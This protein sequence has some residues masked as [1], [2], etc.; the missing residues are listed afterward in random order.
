M[1]HLL[2]ICL[3]ALLCS[4]LSNAQTREAD[5]LALVDLYCQTNGLFWTNSWGLDTLGTPP[6]MDGWY[7]VRM[8][9]TL[10]NGEY[11]VTCLD[12]DGNLG[13]HQWG[14][15]DGGNNL[16]GILPDLNLTELRELY[17]SRNQ[18]ISQI[19]DFSNMP[20]LE[21]LYL[22]DNQLSDS[23]PDFSHFDSLVI[24]D[25]SDNRL[26]GNVIDFDN[27]PHLEELRLDDNRLSDTIP[28]FANLP[29]LRKLYLGGYAHHNGKNNHLTGSLPNF[30]NLK[31]LEELRISYNGLT[32]TIPHFTDLRKLRMLDIGR[33]GLSG[34]VPDFTDLDSLR[35]LNIAYNSLTETIP[36]FSYLDNLTHLYLEGNSLTGQIPEFNRLTALT[37]LYLNDNSLTDT[38]P[39]FATENLL[40]LYLQNNSF[41]QE[42]LDLSNLIN[43]EYLTLNNCNLMGNIDDI[44]DLNSLRGLDISNNNLTGEIPDFSASVEYISMHH[45]C[46]S[47]EVKNVD[48]LP[49]LWYLNLNS[50]DLDGTLTELTFEGLVSLYE[51]DLSHNKLTGNIPKFEL[52]V[53]EA[54]MDMPNPVSNIGRLYLN[55]NKFSGSIP[56]FT[57]LEKLQKLRLNHNLLQGEIPEFNLKRL[58][59]LNLSY[60]NLT[61]SIPTFENTFSLVEPV[62]PMNPNATISRLHELYLNNNNLTGSIPPQFA[63]LSK[64]RNLNLTYNSLDG[65]YSNALFPDFCNQLYYGNNSSNQYISDGNNFDTPWE[66]FCDTGDCMTTSVELCDMLPPLPSP[67]VSCAVRDAII[68]ERIYCRNNGENWVNPWDINAPV[69]TWD[70]VELDSKNCVIG[71]YLSGRNL[72]GDLFEFSNLTNLTMLNLSNNNLTGEILGISTLSMLEELDLNR[73]RLEGIIPNFDLPF[74]TKL[75]LSYND[76]IGSVPSF[77]QSPELEKVSL[78]DNNL[79][80]SVPEYLNLTKLQ[81]LY[82]DHNQLKGQ[83]PNFDS[84]YNL[85]E[86]ELDDNNLTDTIPNFLNL[87]QLQQLHLHENQL[88]GKIP[89]FDSLYNLQRLF[90]KD[91]HLTDTIPNFSN[92]S[93]LIS[94]NA[95]RN[96]LTG[97][98]PDF[99]NLPNLTYLDIYNNNLTEEIPNF[100]NLPNLE[101]LD[102][103]N[104]NLTGEIPNFDKLPN[105][106]Q[107][108]L[109]NN[110]LTGEIPNFDNLPD[111]TNLNLGNN[112]LSGQIPNFNQL[113]TL[114]ELQLQGNILGGNIPNF[115]LPYL[116]KLQLNDNILTGTIP[117]FNYLQQLNDLDINDNILTGQIPPAFVALDNLHYLSIYNNQLDSCY[118]PILS[119]LCQQLN[120]ESNN[121]DNISKGNAF[122]IPWETF[123]A[124]GTA[125]CDTFDLRIQLDS[126]NPTVCDTT[127]GSIFLEVLFG[128]PPYQFKWSGDTLTTPELTELSEGKYYVT[129]TDCK[130]GIAMDSVELKI[131]PLPHIDDI[132]IIDAYCGAAVG[133]LTTHA[134]GGTPPY[135][136][137]LDNMTWQTDSVF[138]NLPGDNTYTVFV[139]DSLNCPADTMATI[140]YV[141]LLRIDSVEI[142]DARCELPNGSLTVF[143]SNGPPPYQYSLDSITWQDSIFFNN[144]SVGDYTIYA[145]DF[146]GCIVDTMVTIGD[147]PRVAFEIDYEDPICGEDNG[148]ITIDPTSGTPPFMYVCN[149]DT[150][151]QAGCYDLSGGEYFITVIDDAGC[152]ADTTITLAESDSLEIDLTVITEPCVGE[153]NCGTVQLTLS[154]WNNPFVVGWTDMGN[155]TFEGCVPVG[156][157]THII[158]DADNCSEEYSISFPEFEYRASVTPSSVT[159]VGGEQITFFVDSTMQ[160]EWLSEDANNLGYLSCTN[161]LE[162]TFTAPTP[163]DVDK[164]E[165]CER[166]INYQVVA[167]NDAGNCTDTL[168]V[169]ITVKNE[170]YIPAGITPGGDNPI[171]I[172]PALEA[173]VSNNNDDDEL[174]YSFIIRNRSGRLV[175]EFK[176][177]EGNYRD[178][179]WDGTYLDTGER[180]PDATYYYRLEFTTG[181]KL[182]Q[183][184]SIFIR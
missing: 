47:G 111:L 83:I 20:K 8:S 118:A 141:E 166:N 91:N 80:G 64:L 60:N 63:D 159:M 179:R 152:Q 41:T 42:R 154:G 86:L 115:N 128:S 59:E 161:C 56:E 145:T 107:L 164:I 155:G 122:T 109:N 29:K 76:F 124:G 40:E 126:I 95:S 39:N 48:N 182:D 98:I 45:N 43:V 169:S 82:L 163:L 183:D 84:L 104:N 19:P 89:D 135:R 116:T 167:Y 108:Y 88:S 61:G 94:L 16:S 37:H 57:D 34:S 49:N 157:S 2:S 70:G 105:L 133:S 180:L 87:T 177:E 144:L 71:L 134:S 156:T 81:V 14:T 9:D 112:I 110:N 123:C 62:D 58:E 73:N 176:D 162:P 74:L 55:G 69:D 151:T 165:N 175:Y 137:S 79:T 72:T 103:H 18:L 158:R 35:Y 102:I 53:P 25:L 46:L 3:I 1:R 15:P 119:Q 113:D 10:I 139:L 90:I 51:L 142:M 17:L 170:I 5:S 96:H 129:V 136:Y 150:L 146:I 65:C 68:L 28:D 143:A 66:D 171:L 7:G 75:D 4:T 120:E 131:P 78:R 30:S 121:N 27:L 85:T 101:F 38:I 22:Y 33:N 178:K 100:D 153:D 26:A 31:E 50:N 13:C 125:I 148:F 11:R 6:P 77:E 52:T 21:K 168:A 184:G 92:L 174:D 172:I 138:L 32:D 24:L 97:Q 106:T 99:D 147:T 93:N 117:N 44:S 23:I 132:D 54:T 67:S 36:N 127:N 160:A 140:D 12:L 130:G 149:E 173:I 181:C 114:I